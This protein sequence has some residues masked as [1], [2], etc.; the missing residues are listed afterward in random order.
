MS[1]S[2]DDFEAFYLARV[3]PMRR[4]A[5][6]VVRDWDAAEDVVQQ[7][8]VKVYVAWPRVRRGTAEAYLRRA[9]VNTALSRVRRTK[10][11][12]AVAEVPEV[13]VDGADAADDPLAILAVL[14][15]AQRAVVALRLL[16]DLSVTET[17]RILRIS[18]GAVKSQTARAL[19][20]LRDHATA[21]GR[22]AGT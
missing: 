3:R 15:P 22:D 18:E 20:K 2:T 5:F 7:A 10:R 17:A 12:V 16:D 21:S 4:V 14:P 8:F 1:T 9:V 13:A 19:A 11:E 6:V